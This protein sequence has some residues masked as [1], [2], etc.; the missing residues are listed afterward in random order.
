MS[1]K[2]FNVTNNLDNYINIEIGKRMIENGVKVRKAD[3]MEEIAEFSNV[4]VYNI[5]MIKR[6]AVTPSLPVAMKIA[7]FFDTSVENLF[8][9]S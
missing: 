5:A 3:I 4:G 8:R 6:N 7:E 2:K 1:R 9:I